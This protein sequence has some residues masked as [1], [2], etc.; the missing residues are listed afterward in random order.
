MSGVRAAW[1]L[2]DDGVACIAWVHPSRL[3]V[4]AM[5][6]RFNRRYLLFVI[7]IIGEAPCLLTYWVGRQGAPRP[8]PLA[9]RGGD[10]RRREGQPAAMPRQQ[11]AMLCALLAWHGLLLPHPLAY[12]SSSS[13]S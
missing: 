11:H 7:I 12:A 13:S 6:D 9:V 5:A 1:C 4:G 10:M 2:L 3:Q 8:Q